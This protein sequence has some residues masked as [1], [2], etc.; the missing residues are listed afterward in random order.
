MRALERNVVID[1]RGG[2]GGTRGR[3]FKALAL[4]RRGELRTKAIFKLYRVPKKARH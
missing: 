1:N 2:L 3:G 4:T